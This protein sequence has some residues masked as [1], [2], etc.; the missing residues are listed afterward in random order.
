MFGSVLTL[1]TLAE[2][3]IID[4]VGQEAEEI[5]EEINSIF[6]YSFVLRDHEYYIV[7]L[8]II[9]YININNLKPMTSDLDRHIYVIYIIRLKNTT[10]KMFVYDLIIAIAKN[11]HKTNC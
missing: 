1:A 10:E 3:L 6:K 2:C 9:G 11:C 7:S 4:A 5:L 8:L